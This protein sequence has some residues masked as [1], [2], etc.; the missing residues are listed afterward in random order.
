MLALLTQAP[1]GRGQSRDPAFL[2][3]WACHEPQEDGAK[4]TMCQSKRGR[5]RGYRAIGVSFPLCHVKNRKSPKWVHVET[6]L[7]NKQLL[8]TVITHQPRE[9]SLLL[10]PGI[11]LL[12][13]EMSRWCKFICGFGMRAYF[14]FLIEKLMG[15]SWAAAQVLANFC[16]ALVS[17]SRPFVI[18]SSVI[19]K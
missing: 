10:L 8:A 17:F 15:F 18:Q 3:P 13:C 1:C 19:N 12:G 7:E 5:E 14:F 2:C 9:A 16:Q 6:V 11:V 4:A